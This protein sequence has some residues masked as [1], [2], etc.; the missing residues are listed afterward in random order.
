MKTIPLLEW[1][2]G[3]R[4]DW[5]R[6]DLIAGLTTAAV[7][8]PKAM[9]YAT[10]A[11]LP[12]EA[13]IYTAFVPM[14]VYAI[15]GTSRP[16]SVSTTTTL[17]ILTGTQL[18]LVAPGGD[19]AALLVAATTLAFL[20]GVMLMLASLLRLGAVAS[21]ISEPVLTGFKA[22]VGLIIVLDQVPKL[23]GI[24][25]DKGTFLQ[26]LVA[27]VQH[28][29][30]TSAATLA[31]GAAMLVILIALERWVPRAPAPLVAVAVGIAASGLFALQGFGVAI[32]G[33]IPQ[34][35]PS[36]TPPSLDLIEQLWPGALGI[37]LMSFT[38]SIAAARAFAGPG[39]PR[40]QPN[41]ELFATGLA[42][43]VGSL[44]GA[45]PGGGGTSQTA[46]NRLAGARTQ[47]AGLTTAAAAVATLLLFAPLMA[48][49][50][51]ATLAAVVIVYSIGLIQPAEF[52]A[53][54]QIRRMEF[55]WALVACA[56]VV[57][58]GTLQGIVVAIV[59]SLVALS[60]QAAHPRVYTLGRKPGTDVFR[61][62]SD[63]HPEDETI[64]GLLLAR[65]E[66]R[67][68]FANAQYVGEQLLALIDEARPQVLA[69]DFSAIPDIEYSAL[70]MLIEGEERLS[71]RGIRLWLVALN[72]QALAVIQ[73]SSL[74]TTLGRERLL[75]NL[76]MTIERYL[77]QPPVAGP[78]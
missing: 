26:N 44:F 77:S 61:P 41:R 62:H 35:L 73:R 1:L 25:F 46:V 24:H 65:A 4:R 59:V 53:I 42:N 2:G 48:L 74:G 31:V 70:K 23:L 49:M 33:P 15:L 18:A 69:L 22:G 14:V 7:V 57:L 11:G 60:Y 38:E 16:L 76:P 78:D 27:L 63:E 20:V 12:V 75:F 52:L 9:A 13:G 71:A 17:A 68:F 10:V 40:P 30:Q 37:A 64:P 58:L 29:P 54:L 34:G 8:I 47:V 39:E 66:G 51:Q 28:L 45:M 36:F 21:F 43:A 3:Y 72:P 32:V 19:P 5:L 56:G 67:I 6:P 55:L 50:P